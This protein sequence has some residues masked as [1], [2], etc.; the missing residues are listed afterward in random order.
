MSE[1]SQH[2]P[3]DAPHS[4]VDPRRLLQPFKEQD[5]PARVFVLLDDPELCR[6]LVAFSTAQV[7]FPS[8]VDKAGVPEDDSPLWLWLWEQSEIDYDEICAASGLTPPSVSVR[9]HQ[10]RTLR[11]IYPDGTVS[12]AALQFL[13]VHVGAEIGR[14]ASEQRKGRSD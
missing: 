6:F 4:L 9:L 7:S 2:P 12:K 8:L 3:Q 14:L 11:L 10:A 5:D 1:L 13:R